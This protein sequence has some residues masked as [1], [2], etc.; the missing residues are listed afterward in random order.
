MT[1][2]TRPRAVVVEDAPEFQR[3]AHRLLEREG[4]DVQLAAT[5]EEGLDLVRREDPELVLIDLLLPGIDGFEV[6]RRL[7]EFSDAYAV[8]V[9]ARDDQTDKVVGLRVGA[10]D[11]V[12]KPYSPAELS[13]RIAALRRRPRLRAVAPQPS[14][15]LVDGALEVDLE[16]REVRV[17][18]A[19]VPLT[20]TEFDLLQALVTAPRRVLT[21]THLVEVVWGPGGAD[22]HVV[23]VH[24]GNLRRKI[25]A[26]DPSPER[27][28]TVR[29]VG[30]RF[31]PGAA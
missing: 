28:V 19:S 1:V 27:F 29:G 21:R 3:L 26:A 7:R 8:M 13:A 12:T 5:G 14:H 10:D 23:D 20:R 18:G 9:T 30:Y 2:P 6:C 24:V 17:S 16:A 31:Q 11:Y 15:C 22:P 4:Y 25:R